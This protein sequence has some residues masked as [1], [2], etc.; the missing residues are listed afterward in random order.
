MQWFNLYGLIFMTVIMIPNIVFA[1]R[2]KD[3]F[4]NVL[5]NRLIEC[6]EQIGRFSCF[7]LMVINIP[8]AWLGFKSKTAFW[9]YLVVNCVL[10][11]SYCLIWMLYFNK[12][13]IF[14]ALAL[15]ILPSIIFLFSGII[16][17]YIL[18]VIGALIFA[19]CHIIISYNNTVKSKDN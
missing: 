15:S 11:L 1:V 9:V 18:L 14:R 8:G 6:L 5:H 16:S 12:N 3:S 2:C 4:N 10:I 7:G 19:P 13:C 17:R